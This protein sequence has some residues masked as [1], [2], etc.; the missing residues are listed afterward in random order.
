MS[1]AG[2]NWHVLII[3]AVT[4]GCTTYAGPIG[5]HGLIMTQTV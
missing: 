4:A 5:C 1:C 3:L 2:Y